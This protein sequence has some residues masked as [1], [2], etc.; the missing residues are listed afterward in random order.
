[1][2]EEWHKK[3]ISTPAG[4]KPLLANV[5]TALRT[6]P[7]WHSVLAYDAFGMQTIADLAPPWG[8]DGNRIWTP[9]DD[10]LATDWMQRHGIGV[11]VATTEKAVETVARD[12]SFHPVIDYLDQLRHDG[13]GRVGNWLSAYLGAAENAYHQHVGRAMLVGAVARIYKPGCKNDTMPIFEGVQGA[14]KSTAIRTLFE[15]WFTD[16]L[17]DFGSKDSAMQMRGAWGIEVSELDAMSKSEVSRIKAFISRTTDRFRPP[18]GSRIIE[19]PRSCV[20]WGSTNSDRYLKDETGGRRFWPVKVGKIDIA[21]LTEAREQLWAEAVTLFRADYPWWIIKPDILRQVED[22]QRQRY[23]GDVWDAAVERYVQG[24]TQVSLEK[25]M[26]DGVGLDLAR[27]GQPEQNRVVACLKSLGFQRTQVRSGDK[28]HWVYR[29]VVTN[30][31][32]SP[33]SE[34]VTTLKVVTPAKVVTR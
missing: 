18:Y 33:S 6:C 17:A 22:E 8:G 2:S 32:N 29:R 19:S 3:L 5:V 15:P 11:N 34:V 30:D 23:V 16:E 12:R 20:F 25:V 28:R 27:C 9:D 14:L 1:M 21:G 13:K 4:P 24:E 26:R 7:Q 31:P 10:V